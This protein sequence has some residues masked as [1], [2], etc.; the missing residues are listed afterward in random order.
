[1][2][3]EIT[4]ES[5]L[6]KSSFWFAQNCSLLSAE[7]RD[8]SKVLCLFVCSLFPPHKKNHN[9]FWCETGGR[10]LC[11][12]AVSLCVPGQHSEELGREHLRKQAGDVQ[13][14]AGLLHSSHHHQPSHGLHRLWGAQEVNVPHPLN[15]HHCS[16]TKNRNMP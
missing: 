9:S 12:D 3:W 2:S 10:L 15:Q 4:F 8:S 1:M 14:N 6:T 11:I 13:D 5:C 7:E 16:K